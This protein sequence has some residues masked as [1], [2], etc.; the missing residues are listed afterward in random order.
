MKH[1]IR[2][3]TITLVAFLFPAGALTGFFAS[4]GQT[5]GVR[6]TF[7]TAV[8]GATSSGEAVTG[9]TNGRGWKINLTSARAAMGPIYFYSAEAQAGLLRRL[10]GD[11]AAH[12]CSAHAQY[13][14]GAVLG[15]V[16][17]QYAVDLL[18]GAATDTGSS[19]GVEGRC[20]MFE[21]HFHPPGG[22]D[23]GSAAPEFQALKGET[24]Q[25]AGRATRGGQTIAF[26]GGL[27]LPDEGTMR[28]VE[29]IPADLELKDGALKPGQAVVEVLLDQWFWNVDFAS[30][31][32][33]NAATGNFI[34]SNE[35]Q[36]YLAWLTGAKS[37]H[38]Y[39]IAWRAP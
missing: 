2:T 8:A 10:L 29:S 34:I 14:R 15:E 31:T 25:V 16:L 35:T 36:A 12:A 20:R 33:K 7:G 5:G 22:I 13:D 39:R 21:V 23:A 28:I 30:L 18:K 37:R 24:F 38:S 4:C 11:S 27:T 1:I 6:I 17:R 26:E 3:A 19:L 9:F 32:R